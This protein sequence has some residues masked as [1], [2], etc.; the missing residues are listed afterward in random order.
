MLTE[1]IQ[2]IGPF[3]GSLGVRSCASSSSISPRG[4]DTED[5]ATSGVYSCASSSISPR[6]AEDGSNSGVDSALSRSPSS[7]I[8]S[9]TSR[10][11]S[12]TPDVGDGTDDGGLTEEM[13]KENEMVKEQL[14]TEEEE[15][16]RNLLSAAD[17]GE[18]GQKYK[19]LEFLLQ[20]STAYTQYLFNR[21]KSQQEEIR[22]KA[23][24][25]AK[26]EAKKREKQKEKNDEEEKEN[27]QE[28]IGKAPGRKQKRKRNMIED[29]D[30]DDDPGAKKAKT[31]AAKTVESKGETTLT[32]DDILPS[33]PSRPEILAGSKPDSFSRLVNG[34]K[35][36]DLQPQL[37]TGGVLREYQIKG[38]TWMKSLFENGING[39]LADE[40]GLGKTVQ[41]ISLIAHLISEQ[42][43]GPFLVVAPLSTIP[44]WYSEFKRFTPHIPVMIHHGA[45]EARLSKARKIYKK[46]S[47]GPWNVQPVVLS[48]YEMIIQDRKVIGHHAWKCLI[49]DEGHRLKNMNCRLI[50]ELKMFNACNRLL[51]TGTPLQNNLSE[52]WSL[53]NFLLPEIFDDLTSFESWFDMSLVTEDG[54]QA[55]IVRAEKE[56]NVLTTLHSI[57]EPFLLRRLKADV[58]LDIPPKREVLV[59]APL[60]KEQEDYYKS[61][62]DKSI[63]SLINAENDDDDLFD[64]L[65]SSTPSSSTPSS[66]AS[67]SST[68]TTCDDAEDRIGGNRRKSRRDI[69][70]AFFDSGSRQSKSMS[71]M[72]DE[73]KMRKVYADES[74]DEEGEEEANDDWY[75]QVSRM[76]SERER[77]KTEIQSTSKSG[78]VVRLQLRNVMML[79]RKVCNHPFLINYEQSEMEKPTEKVVNVCGKMMILDQMLVQLKKKGHKVLIFS[80]MTQMLD[81]I[82][83]YLDYRGF[84]H[85]RLDGSMKMEDRQEHIH[86]FNT[87]PER[88]VF[89]LSTRAGGL[90]LNLMTADTVIIYDSDWN[91]QCDLQAQDRAH[92]MGQKRPVMVYRFITANTIDQKIVERAAAKRRLEKMVIKRGRFQNSDQQVEKLKKAISPQELLTLLQSRDQEME[93]RTSNTRV[94]KGNVRWT[95]TD[96]ECDQLL[97]RSDLYVRWEEERKSRKRLVDL[98]AKDVKDDAVKVEEEEEYSLKAADTLVPKTN[99]IFAVVETSSGLGVEDLA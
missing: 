35:V 34:E 24:K 6:D 89:L 65:P 53:L 81:I 48:S 82:A 68:S 4:A 31:E 11:P 73:A 95:L 83:D 38:Y 56:N 10:S 74:S 16:K 52:L 3:D 78:N 1:K 25:K 51:L 39:I 43:Q 92:R 23:E 64:A 33:I 36:S 96:K 90:G 30:D 86:S 42:C 61:A 66:I 15:K 26:K 91:P 99:G 50:R 97:D 21:M 54:G 47:A 80:Q 55:E 79:L 41:C 28:I 2:T 87:D 13:M 62:V 72:K 63:A 70:Y 69:N 88:F 7:G 20:K 93:I 17:K 37:F 14:L 8:G 40:M 58:K 67:S 46:S 22:R 71:L 59:Y 49:I 12:P 98:S 60:T 27:S 94:S 32:D 18:S 57:L 85:S 75:E 19:Q 45:K 77:Q 44:N 9:G 84:D 76:T 5:G 29:D